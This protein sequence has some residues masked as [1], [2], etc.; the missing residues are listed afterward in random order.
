MSEAGMPADTMPAAPAVQT[1]LCVNMGRP[2]WERIFSP[3]KKALLRERYG[4]DPG[5]EGLP[6]N[7]GGVLAGDSGAQVMLTSW[8]AE[9]LGPEL[10]SR[11]PRLRL[12]VHGA[13]SIKALVTPEAVAR[14]LRFCSGARVN[15]QPV[16]EFCLGV[17][18]CDLKRVFSW[19]ERF[20]GAED[21]TAAWWGAHAGF[22][23]GYYRKNIGL[24]GWGE[25]S[26]CLAG[27]LRG[28][29]L[30]V[31]VFSRHLSVAEIREY[32]VSPAALDWIMANCDVVSLHSADTPA[33]RHQIN[34]DNLRLMKPNSCL[35]NTARGGI[36]DEEALAERLRVGD[37]RA[38]LDVAKQEPPPRG[39]PFYTLPNCILTPHVSGSIGT[40]THR[41]GDY[42]MREFDN[43][44]AGKPLE[45]EMILDQLPERA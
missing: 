21:L 23:G 34:R 22:D 27:L 17:I 41:L 31:F 8:G 11:F 33:N 18:L 1:G 28:F 29:D 19:R 9:P 36:V 7:R 14:G 37:M 40:E 13:G 12:V 25:I 16:A 6:H 4:I 45:H 5:P 35:L 15:A 26:R 44:L 42:C 24:V 3:E 39:H 20:A 43:F 32:R 10:L 2:G 38:C 30:N